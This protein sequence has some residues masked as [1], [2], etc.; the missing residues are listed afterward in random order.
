MRAT[1]QSRRPALA[2]RDNAWRR[3]ECSDWRINGKQGWIYAIPKGF[4]LCYFARNGVNE[5]DG[6]GTHQARTDRLPT[7]D[8]AGVIRDSL[9]IFKK[10][11]MGEPSEAQKAARLALASKSVGNTVYRRPPPGRDDRWSHRSQPFLLGPLIRPATPDARRIV[12]KVSA[13]GLTVSSSCRPSQTSRPQ[14]RSLNL[15]SLSRT[16]DL[17][18]DGLAPPAISLELSNPLGRALPLELGCLLE[19]PLPNSFD[20]NNR[21]NRCR[22]P[23]P[24]R[25]RRKQPGAG[26]RS[27]A[28]LV[29]LHHRVE[30]PT[31]T[32]RTGTV[33]RLDNLRPYANAKQ[34]HPL[35]RGVEDL[36]IVPGQL[37]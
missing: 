32:L 20:I 11:D 4:Q 3:D 21:G 26:E 9:V 13:R 30:T 7:P 36:W 33:N 1:Q 22:S 5:F 8:E 6:E 27:V 19:L 35:V 2:C 14:T 37:A 31:A 25:R 12:D 10:R 17:R 15:R 24:P 23:T 18:D 28:K 34:I 29:T 16:I